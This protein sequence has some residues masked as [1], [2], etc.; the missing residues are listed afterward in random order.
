M[1]SW[2]Y[3][4]VSN[5]FYNKH[6]K[7][8]TLKKKILVLGIAFFLLNSVNA[9]FTDD[10]ESYTVGTMIF[11]NYWTDWS[12]SGSNSIFSSDI[13]SASGSLS[14]YIPSNG[15]TDGILDLGNKVTGHWGL[16]FMMYIPSNKEAQMNIQKTV[17]V[18]SNPVWAIGNIYF[19]KDNANPGTGYVN[20]QSSSSS[21]WS[22][23]SFP[24]DQWFEV[25]INVNINNTWQLLIDG[26]VEI[27][28]TDY[29]RWVSAGSFQYTNGLGGI[30]FFSSSSNCEYWIDDIDFIS[31]FHTSTVSVNENTKNKK[32]VKVYPN[33]TTNQVYFKIEN[34]EN[35]EIY[36]ITGKLIIKTK[37]N[38]I[39]MEDV[40]N[41]VYLYKIQKENKIINGSIIKK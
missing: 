9:Q 11:E 12:G 41:G 25:I 3:N 16:K 23:F 2:R 17:P 34:F 5:N 20:Y 30:N 31:G 21:N 28:W 22:F 15:T 14:G 6:I 18:G 39:R 27:D 26:N 13:H 10:M 4:Y 37:S 8:N 40:Q 35:I 29:G 38:V 32:D 19:N 1:N 36:D 33:P 24:H 7:Y